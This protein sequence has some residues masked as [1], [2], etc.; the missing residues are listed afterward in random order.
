MSNP[1]EATPKKIG[2]SM[3]IIAWVIVF[4]MLSVAFQEWQEK[5]E[6][7]NQAPY[8]QLGDS[9]IREVE[10]IR[11]SYNA[12]IT[13][14]T[15]NDRTVTFLLDTGATDVVIPEGLAKKMKLKRGRPGIAITANGRV[16]TFATRIDT[17]SVGNIVLT[18]IPASIN[19]GMTG[20]AV[21]LGM[22]ALKNIEFSQR[23]NKMILRQYPSQ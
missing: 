17:L 1:A 22:S 12:Y 5:K 9:G 10:L 11:N 13:N 19:P 14:G 15:I 20:N 8:S 2:T 7:P 23:G 16:T 3:L 21:L 6:N 4:I 18:D